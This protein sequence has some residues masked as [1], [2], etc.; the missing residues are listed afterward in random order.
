M[1]YNNAFTDVVIVTNVLTYCWPCLTFPLILMLLLLC[2]FLILLPYCLVCWS[3]CCHACLSNCCPLFSHLAVQ[4]VVVLP[5]ISPLLLCCHPIV[6]PI[7]AYPNVSCYSFLY[8]W[9]CSQFCLPHCLLS[10]S[11]YCSTCEKLC[12]QSSLCFDNLVVHLLF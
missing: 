7:V 11:H 3:P 8:S 9:C 4:P 2:T 10:S 5:V 1:Y 12:C 6:C